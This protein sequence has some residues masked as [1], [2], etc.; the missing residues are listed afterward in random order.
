MGRQAH[1]VLSRLEAKHD[2]LPLCFM[3]RRAGGAGV[4]VAGKADSEKLLGADAG[5]GIKII[6]SLSA[7]GVL[8][9]SSQGRWRLL[10]DVQFHG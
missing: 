7:G 9:R 3:S 1:A 10:Y 8:L 4:T 2:D 5:T 6:D